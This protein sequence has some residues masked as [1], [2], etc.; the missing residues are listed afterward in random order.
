MGVK[1]ILKM[2]IRILCQTLL[3]SIL[4]ISKYFCKRSSF[5]LSRRKSRTVMLISIK[6]STGGPCTSLW[7]I[8]LSKATI[9]TRKVIKELF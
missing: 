4:S 8:R 3:P 5:A 9:G 1:E 2:K 6:F 7:D